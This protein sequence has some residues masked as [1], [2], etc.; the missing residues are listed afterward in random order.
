MGIVSVQSPRADRV[1]P[2][3]VTRTGCSDNSATK[4]RI[5]FGLELDLSSLGPIDRT[6]AVELQREKESTNTSP[7]LRIFRYFVR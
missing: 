6:S 1:I 3:M 2:L 5:R 4:L 7:N